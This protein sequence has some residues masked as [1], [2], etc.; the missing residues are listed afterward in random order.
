[1][2]GLFYDIRNYFDQ[3][4]SGRYISRLLRELA[5]H[6]PESFCQII[7][8]AAR[9]SGQN[10]AQ[11][12][13]DIRQQKAVVDC[14]QVFGGASRKRIADLAILRD[15]QPTLLIEVKEDDVRNP[16]NYAQIL[17]Y[18][19]S[20]LPFVY[21]SRFPPEGRGGGTLEAAAKKGQP[22]A[23]IRYRD[24]HRILRD[25]ER[26]FA[27]MFREYL[28]D[29]GVGTYRQI[30]DEITDRSIAFAL[31]QIL[32]FPHAQGLGRLH[33]KEAI[34]AVPQL[35]QRMLD[36]LE[37]TAEWVHQA[38]RP[39][40]R[41]QFIRGFR[42]IP[43]F[44]LKS[45]G[46]SVNKYVETYSLS[47]EGDYL[48]GGAGQYLRGG[49]VLFYAYGSIWS[50]P[51]VTPKLQKGKDYV[52]IELG[53]GFRVHRGKGRDRRGKA[54]QP[55]RQRIVKP[56]LYVRF[57]GNGLDDAY[58]EKQSKVFP[59]EPVAMKTFA[60]LLEKARTDACRKAKSAASKAAIQAIRIPALP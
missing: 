14:E 55:S 46:N 4:F 27:V 50:G 31:T 15:Q 8:F 58:H 17:D 44:D 28:E 25:N 26:P 36:N 47:R 37:Y 12:S 2:T 3:G 33:T 40:I 22:V 20:G 9:S 18:L 59:S 21:L 29:I 51:D 45:L 57:W 34:K 6:E 1:M 54:R 52:R 39:S 30:E 56:F 32:G 19:K 42:P 11:I 38:N 5:R 23:S 13:T 43:W 60:A 24:L 16:S 10:W 41:T 53:F 48:P 7:G 35:M 49:E